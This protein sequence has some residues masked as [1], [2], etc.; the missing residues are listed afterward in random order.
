[1]TQMKLVKMPKEIKQNKINEK[2]KQEVSLIFKEICVDTLFNYLSIVLGT[3]FSSF[4]Q[5]RH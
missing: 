4:P 5:I 3:K 2:Q 1:M